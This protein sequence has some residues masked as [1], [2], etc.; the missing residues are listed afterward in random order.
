LQEVNKCF[1][2]TPYPKL[3]IPDIVIGMEKIKCAT[4]IDLNRGYYSMPLSEQAK[5]ACNQLTLGLASV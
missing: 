5:N 1:K 3:K 4:T 2:C